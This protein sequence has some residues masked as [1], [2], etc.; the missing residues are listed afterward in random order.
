MT[1]G[2][3]LAVLSEQGLTLGIREV[4]TAVE[5]DIADCLFHAHTNTH[6]HTDYVDTTTGG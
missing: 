6:T 5:T 3:F 2:V 4:D 1:W